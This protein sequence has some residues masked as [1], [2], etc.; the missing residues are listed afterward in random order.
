M[1][2][3]RNERLSELVDFEDAPTMKTIKNIMIVFMTSG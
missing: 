2:E 1:E 3:E